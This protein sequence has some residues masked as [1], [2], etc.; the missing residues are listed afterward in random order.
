MWRRKMVFIL[1]FILLAVNCA[2]VFAG[3]FYLHENSDY[4][5]YHVDKPG[6]YAVVPIAADIY[7][8]KTVFGYEFLEISWDDGTVI[9]EVGVVPNSSRD[10]VINFVAKRW[11]P[12]LNNERVFANREITTSNGLQTYFYAVEGSGPNGTKSMLRSVYF[13]RDNDVVYLA[14]Y[15]PNNKYQGKVEHYWIR[16][17]NDFEW[18]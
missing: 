10:D 8:T 1:S 17:V 16:A 9:M 11:S 6:F 15:L 5:W 2:G 14:M 7:V 18:D 13:S 4:W 3:E 12:F